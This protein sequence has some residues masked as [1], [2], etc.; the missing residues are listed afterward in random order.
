MQP[1]LTFIQECTDNVN[2]LY[3]QDD[4]TVILATERACGNMPTESSLCWSIP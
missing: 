3:V 4:G 2:G 1:K